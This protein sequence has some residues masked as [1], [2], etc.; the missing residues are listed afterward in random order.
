MKLNLAKGV[1]NKKKGFFKHISSKRKI[2][3]NMGSLLSDVGDLVMEDTEQVESLN[4]FS[5]SV[6]TAKAS[7]QELQNLKA[8]EKV[9]REKTFP[10]SRRIGLET[11]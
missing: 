9:W 6:S 1:K 5:A 8:R 10:W 7:P 2:R 3:D 4:A 11:I